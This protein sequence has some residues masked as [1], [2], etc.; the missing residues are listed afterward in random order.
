MNTITA[1]IY[2]VP[3]TVPSMLS[4]LIL[5]KVPVNVY[6]VIHTLFR[7]LVFAPY[8]FLHFSL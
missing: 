3:D 1:T 2:Q 8:S 7:F 4:N 5:A 6:S